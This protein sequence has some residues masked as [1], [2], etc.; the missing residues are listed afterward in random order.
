MRSE[1]IFP[2]REV[3]PSAYPSL[4]A[5]DANQGLTQLAGLD[6]E[7]P[8]ARCDAALSHAFGILGKRWN[9]MILGSLIEAPGGFSELRRGLGGISDSVLS[10]RLSELTAAGVVLREVD[11]GPPVAVRYR[12]SPSGEALAPVLRDLMAWAREN[13]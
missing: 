1:V 3:G 7:H 10:D 13:L 4:V 6:G 5:E 9:G 8:V 11:P 12:L 2:A